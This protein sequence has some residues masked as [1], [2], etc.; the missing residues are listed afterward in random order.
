VL[1]SELVPRVVVWQVETVWLLKVAPPSDRIV[2]MAV[3]LKI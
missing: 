2:P 3:L 1:P